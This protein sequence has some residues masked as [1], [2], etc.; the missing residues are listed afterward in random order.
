MRRTKNGKTL[1]VGGSLTILISF[2]VHLR[3]LY[4]DNFLLL[5][6]E[7]ISRIAA[8]RLLSRCEDAME[9]RSLPCGLWAGEWGA[10]L[11]KGRGSRDERKAED[12]TK[13]VFELGLETV[14]NQQGKRPRTS[15]R[16]SVASEHVLLPRVSES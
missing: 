11:G 13:G 3:A 12:F 7:K 9:D 8:I 4:H 5:E 2:F 1:Q 15:G 10:G 14:P 16:F 6:S